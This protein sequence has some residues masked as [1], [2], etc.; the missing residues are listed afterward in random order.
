MSSHQFWRTLAA[1]SSPG[2]KNAR[3]S[4]LIYHSVLPQFDPMNPEEETATSFS[5]K[6]ELVARRFNVLPL[7]EAVRRLEEGSLPSRALCITFDDGYANNATI[8]LPILQRLGIPATFF[9]AT[10]FLNG[11]RMWNDTVFESARRMPTGKINLNFSKHA[12]GEYRLNTMDDRLAMAKALIQKIKYLS[13]DERIEVTEWLSSQAEA[14]LPDD[15]MMTSRQVKELHS[16]GMEIGGHTMNHPILARLESKQ[17]YDEI[18][19]GKA[20]LEAIIGEPL[21]LFAYPNGKPQQDYLSEH[22][23]IVRE[24]GFTAA[25]STTPGVATRQTDRWQIPRF[26]PWDQT[27]SRFMTRL[28]LNCRRTIQ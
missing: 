4:T 14:P 16:A 8:A 21:K 22:T 24:I 12:M 23:Q 5:W 18:A 3:L 20:T 10:G 1:F 9:V 15:L 26:T 27:P 28:L 2:G 19:H 6:M 25:V 17:A 11:G 7:G 13:F